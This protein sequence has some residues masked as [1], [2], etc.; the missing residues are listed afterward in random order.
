MSNTR[1]LPT[2]ACQ[3]RC[4]CSEMQI[5]SETDTIDVKQNE[6][7]KGTEENN[8]GMSNESNQVALDRRQDSRMQI[9]T[10]LLCTI[11]NEPV[12]V[13]RHSATDQ[14]FAKIFV[15]VRCKH[16]IDCRRVQR[17]CSLNQFHLFVYDIFSENELVGMLNYLKCFVPIG[18]SR[19]KK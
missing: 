10:R 15:K 19:L 11:T 1:E 12:V 13:G 17:N 2:D 6:D 8:Q 14:K 7:I 3:V 4:D 18:E 9:A 16:P 5:D